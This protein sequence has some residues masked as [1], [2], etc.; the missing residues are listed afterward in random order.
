MTSSSPMSRLRLHLHLRLRLYLWLAVGLLLVQLLVL[1]VLYLV[2]LPDRGTIPGQQ[3][4]QVT[5]ESQEIP[6]R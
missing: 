2:P 4:V 1:E 6:G 5:G 3:P